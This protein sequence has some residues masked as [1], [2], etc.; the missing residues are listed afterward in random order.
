MK[1]HDIVQ[2]DCGPGCSSEGIVTA[3]DKFTD[4]VVVKDLLDGSIWKGDIDKT[5]VLT[6]EEVD[7]A[8]VIAGSNVLG[9]L[10]PYP[11][12]SRK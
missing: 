9:V 7:E 12:Q 2:F 4:E 8:L 11:L 1:L 5:R 10:L 6:P 3:I